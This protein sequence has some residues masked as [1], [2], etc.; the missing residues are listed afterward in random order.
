MYDTVM[1]HSE[2]YLSRQHDE[3][4]PPGER[5]QDIVVI[6]KE[7]KEMMRTGSTRAVG[8]ISIYVA[9]HSQDGTL[10]NTTSFCTSHTEGNPDQIYGM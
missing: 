3:F 2:W 1:A 7:K 5:A 8:W 10:A 9:S 6:K 4:L